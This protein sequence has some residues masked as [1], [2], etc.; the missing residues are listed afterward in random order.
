MRKLISS[1]AIVGSSYTFSFNKMSE[2]MVHE[3]T[4]QLINAYYYDPLLGYGI[5]CSRYDHHLSEHFNFKA[6]N[7]NRERWEQNFDNHSFRD[8]K[9]NII[10]FDLDL[11]GDNTTDKAKY[12]VSSNESIIYVRGSKDI[13]Y[14]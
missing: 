13:Y 2:R 14:S 3:V 4:K 12:N 10:H 9:F 7:F 11:D 5:T 6:I 1:L 8:H